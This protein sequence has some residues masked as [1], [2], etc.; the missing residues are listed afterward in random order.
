MCEP[1]TITALLTSVVGAVA[2]RA[3]AP[4]APQMPAAPPPPSAPP[5]PQ[6]AKLP[7]QAGV[8]AQ[9]SAS[10][11]LGSPSAAGTMLTG[12]SGVSPTL[13]ALG[14]NTLLGL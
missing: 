14:K 9:G 1:A 13:L 10:G 4:S 12:A 6:G 3:L 11:G 2:S 8:R 5:Q 7:E